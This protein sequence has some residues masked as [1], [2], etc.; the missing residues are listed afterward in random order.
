MAIVCV[1]AC[2][3]APFVPGCEG[4]PSLDSDD[5]MDYQIVVLFF[6]GMAAAELQ[7]G[8]RAQ[9]CDAAAAWQSCHS[10]LIPAMDHSS[11]HRLLVFFPPVWCHYIFVSVHGRPRDTPCL[12][13]PPCPN[14]NNDSW[15][16]SPESGEV[17]HMVLLDLYPFWEQLLEHWILVHLPSIATT[18]SAFS[19]LIWL[20]PL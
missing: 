3:R 4:L 15:L 16:L 13:F 17:L 5:S 9:E 20:Q 19:W 18:I 11:I 14:W 7:T 12:I 1:Y 8:P 6:R 10:V 2:L